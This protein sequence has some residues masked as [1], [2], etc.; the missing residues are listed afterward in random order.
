MEW[1]P[2]ETAPKDGAYI[3]VANAGGVWIAH[4]MPVAVSGYRF[5]DPWRSCMLNHYHIPE[6]ARYGKPTHWAPLPPPPK[7]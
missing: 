7:D 1:Q 6:R 5:D 4:W 2:I 3:Q